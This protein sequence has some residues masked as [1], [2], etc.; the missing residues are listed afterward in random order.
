VIET[1]NEFASDILL[2]QQVK[3]RLISERVADAP[4]S[5]D[6]LDGSTNPPATFYLRS[7]ETQLYAF[8]CSIPGQLADNS[9]LDLF[10]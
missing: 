5:N 6:I 4:W 9:K 2:V 7:L 3:L 10:H 8:K 1:Q